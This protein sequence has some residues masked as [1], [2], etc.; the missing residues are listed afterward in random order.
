M[1]FFDSSFHLDLPTMIA[2]YLKRILD[3]S[4]FCYLKILYSMVDPAVDCMY[5]Q[6]LCTVNMITALL[7][8]SRAEMDVI[9]SYTPVQR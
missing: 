2:F 1:F 6:L 8:N 7:I 3:L 9:C 4:R 5:V